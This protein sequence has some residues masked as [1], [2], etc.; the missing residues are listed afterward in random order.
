MSVPPTTSPDAFSEMKR[1]ML[2]ALEVGEQQLRERGSEMMRDAEERARQITDDA[3]RRAAEVEDQLTQVEQ[4]IAESR[5][6]LAA[7][8]VRAH[9][10]PREK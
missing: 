4:Q 9:N 10:S 6:R 3:D 5:A 1:A 8:R 2:A 7:I